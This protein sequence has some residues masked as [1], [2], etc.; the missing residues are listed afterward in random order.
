MKRIFCTSM[1]FLLL[2]ASNAG[3]AVIFERIEVISHNTPSGWMLVT[4][5]IVDGV[6]SDSP[7]ATY[8]VDGSDDIDMVHMTWGSYDYFV[9]IVTDD[10][11]G[12]P[13]SYNGSVFSWVANDGG[14]SISATGTIP[15]EIRQIELSTN[16]TITGAPLNP[17]LSWYNPESNLH[18]FNVRILDESGELLWESGY[19]AP[20]Q[21]VTYDVT[22][23]TLDP[24]TNYQFRIE[25]YEYFPITTTGNIGVAHLWN[26]SANFFSYSTPGFNYAV[27]CSE[28]RQFDPSRYSFEESSPWY[29]GNINWFML[30]FAATS[31]DPPLSPVYLDSPMCSDGEPFSCGPVQLTYKP[32]YL[33]NTAFHD[34]GFPDTLGFEPPGPAWEEKTYVFFI[35][36]DDDEAWGAGEP[37]REWYIPAGSITQMDIPQNVVISGGIHPTIAWDPVPDADRYMVN[38]YSLTEDGFPDLAVR[39]HT[40][41]QISDTSYT[42]NGDMFTDGKEYAV[43]VQAREFHPYVGT[44]PDYAS[45]FINRSGYFTTYQAA[46]IEDVLESCIDSVSRGDLEGSGPGSSADNRLGALINKFEAAYNLADQGDIAAACGQ[47]ESA[48][49]KTDGLGP[50]QS[51]PDFVTGPAASQL[52]SMI[53]QAMSQLQCSDYGF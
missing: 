47:L 15:S 49:K 24:R 31:G 4:D 22:G 52:A 14:D 37:K 44:D 7:T 16:F 43:W 20:D 33:T 17:T 18:H 41:G 32:D 3:A 8:S 19:I 35:D 46:E 13:D 40:S 10:L 23:F 27:L 2:L 50:P 48:Y 39:L 1:F 6:L 30:T 12:D 11:G 28:A 9:G 26:R 42:Y 51:P 21:D 29:D 45:W 25:A 34:G 53:E 5:L 38:F 36:A